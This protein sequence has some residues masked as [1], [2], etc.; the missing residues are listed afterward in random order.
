MS[1][2]CTQNYHVTSS[3]LL[4][5]EWIFLIILFWLLN[6]IVENLW[7][8]ILLCHNF[9]TRPAVRKLFLAICTEMKSDDRKFS[10]AT[11]EKGIILSFNKYPMRWELWKV[12]FHCMIIFFFYS[13]DVSKKDFLRKYL[14]TRVKW[15]KSEINFVNLLGQFRCHKKY[16]GIKLCRELRA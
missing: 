12:F 3:L 7:L 6:E 2:K 16:L 5:T 11:H 15:I 10:Q 8:H 13:I 14:C 4:I 1:H 9:K